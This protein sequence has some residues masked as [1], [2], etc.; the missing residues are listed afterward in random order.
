VGRRWGQV[1]RGREDRALDVFNETIELYGQMQSDG[2]IES[3]DL[4]LLDPHGGELQ[5]YVL[6]RGS[7]DQIDAVRRDE[8]LERVMIKA[9]L[10]VDDLGLIRAQV[11]EGLAR[12]M[13]IYQE[14][15]AVAH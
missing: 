12:S 7:E 6:L 8:H 4:A 10:V 14:Q 9:S 3:F 13:A 11:G 2:R 15:L 5:G 1:V